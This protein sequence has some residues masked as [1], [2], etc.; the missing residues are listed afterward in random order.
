[1][2]LDRTGEALFVAKYA[3]VIVDLP[4]RAVDRPF[5][6]LIPPELSGTLR[7]GHRVI[8]P[9]GGQ[10]LVGYVIQLDHESPVDDVK[11]II[12]ILDEE[13]LLTEEM[14]ELAL[15]LADHTY[16][17]L[18][19]ALRCVLPGGIHIKSEKYVTLADEFEATDETLINLEVRAPKQAVALRY[20]LDN[21]GEALFD[22]I[23]E[24]T[25]C[26][27]GSITGL[28]EKGYAIV[29][30]RWTDPAV[31]VKR[32]QVCRL[33]QSRDNVKAW[34]EANQKRAP[35]QAA[36]IACLL[37]EGDG[38]STSVL[39]AQANTSP[40]TVRALVEKGL[41]RRHW[42]EVYRDPYTGGDKT[43]FPL[44]PNA[45]QA[46]AL[47]EITKALTDGRYGVFLLRGVTGSGKTEVYLQA[48]AKTLAAGKQAIVLVPEI[49][50][51]PQTVRRFKARFGQR[52]AVLHSA[53]SPGE[54]YD[55]WR[56]IRSGDADIVVGARSAVFAPFT[57]LGLI[58]IDEEHE[59]S[60]KQEEMPRYHARDVALW[61][62]G[63]H[64]AV[65]L[66]GSATPAVESAYMAEKGIYQALILPQR[67]EDRPL[68]QVEIIDM[69]QEL[70][71]GNRTILSRRLREA[72]SQC[73]HRQEQMIILLNR[74]GY[75]TCVL[76]RECGHVLQCT[77]C[78][79]SL[80]YHEPDES[81][82]CHY[83]GLEMPVP[84]RCP[85]CR[86]RYL[87]RFG[88]GTQRVEEV[89]R[90]EFP[91]ARLL[92][93]DF[94]TT[95]RKG[96]HGA[97][98]GQFGRGDADILLGTQM[99]AKGL[100]FPNVTLVGVITADTALNIP[101]FRAGERT[102][103][104][105]TQVGGR[106]GRG[107]KKGEVIIQ[108]YTPNHYSIEA[109]AR[110]DYLAFYH[111]ELAFRR[112]LAYPPYSFLARILISGP[113]EEEVIKTAHSITDTLRR[114]MH[115]QVGAELS[116]LGPSPAPLSM[117]RNRYRWHTL[118]KGEET[119]VRLALA[120]LVGAPPSFSDCSVS[121]DAAPSSLL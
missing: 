101:D 31:R 45:D 119:A 36:V 34:I 78:R 116:I 118:L 63:K 92:R 70:Q 107:D 69:R 38:L 51:T 108:T 18:V 121:V 54:R 4:S 50:L 105:L 59:Q 17:R 29:R 88:V 33:N 86:G 77:N 89:L 90:H 55:E 87:R 48:I 81:V 37:R 6:Y 82:R 111:E 113:E 3:K 12:R 120:W 100:D 94:D 110:Q 8:V 68:P 99:I 117:V 56:R 46:A 114:E 76:C 43:S 95:R 106:A 11:P 26:G 21:E 72:I 14:V 28:V 25:D 42:Q 47:R 23:M 22:T 103:Q 74:R 97:I 83:C 49:S 39:A 32:T 67:I 5:H 24:V 15:W 9:F 66:L 2:V 27:A 112:E 75:A 7:P 102:F 85:E 44:T 71:S 98:L 62:A 73:L 40:S 60:Y 53:L 109:A 79:V 96:A 52:V 13:P 30:H 61:R 41:I 91:G 58:V 1:M 57:N 104:L 64:R 19:D 10:L 84:R 115:T 65:V 80:K 93:M 16:S 35:K 20:L